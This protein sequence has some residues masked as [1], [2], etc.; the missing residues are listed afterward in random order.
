MLFFFLLLGLVGCASVPETFEHESKEP[1][2][3]EYMGALFEVGYQQAIAG[4]VWLK[5][6][7]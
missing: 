2:D 3:P 7:E 1:F 6:E 4:E 5:P